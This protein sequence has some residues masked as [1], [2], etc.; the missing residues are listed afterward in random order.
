[1]D[2]DPPIP[3]PA[4]E[5]EGAGEGASRLKQRLKAIARWMPL[6]L[7][8]AGGIAVFFFG[9]ADEL[10]LPQIIDRRAA[11]ADYVDQ[12]PF[13]TIAVYVGL[14]VAAVVF[15]VPGGSV[16]T[17]VG[18]VLF[19]GILGGLITTAAAV[20]GSILVFLVARTAL[21]GWVKRRMT[22]MGPRITGFA[23]GFRTNAFYVIIVLRL[24]PV[25]PYWASNALPALFGVRLWVFAAATAVG[26]LP[27]TVSFAFFG[28]A[29]DGIVAA[30]EIANPGCVE[31]Q[32]C[33][34]D[35]SALW[36][37][38]VLTGVVIALLAMVPVVAHWWSGRR[39]RAETN[40]EAPSAEV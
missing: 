2:E 33:V 36:S 15:S 16:L 32:T 5:T 29:L 40:A 31:A 19:G 34:F 28:E 9:F 1:M 8:T 14:Y 3:A 7:L 22:T 13:V 21:A 17:I 23:E 38:P 26:L 12:Q 37:G 39:K 27:W 20:A 6:V 24:I 35:F 4:T 11:L 30:Q 18:G 10:S 25:M